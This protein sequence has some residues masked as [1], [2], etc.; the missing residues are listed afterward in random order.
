M[1]KFS[2][3]ICWERILEVPDSHWKQREKTGSLLKSKGFLVIWWGPAKLGPRLES[4]MGG[5]RRCSAQVHKWCFPAFLFWRCISWSFVGQMLHVCLLEHHHPCQF[6][7]LLSSAISEPRCPLGIATML[8]LLRLS[9]K[10]DT[11][12]NCFFSSSHL[13]AWEAMEGEHSKD[14]QSHHSPQCPLHCKEPAGC[15]EQSEAQ[16][17]L[18]GGC[19][20]E[21]QGFNLEVRGWQPSFSDFPGQLQFHATS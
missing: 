9:K 20:A 5:R 19:R 2:G 18:M 21:L 1:C 13:C 4:S 7:S 16:H 12:I 6:L 11:R 15:R 14:G 10:R 8:C 17:S 3:K